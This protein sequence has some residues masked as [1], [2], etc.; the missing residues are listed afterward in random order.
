LITILYIITDLNIGGAE[1][2][3]FR[4]LSKLDKDK[5]NPVVISIA[6]KGK[7]GK[8]IEKEGIKVFSLNINSFI[9][10]FPGILKLFYR[11]R[12]INPRIIHTFLVHSALLSLIAKMKYSSTIIWNIFSSDLSY[13]SNNYLTVIVI[14]I[15]AL[16]SKFV[17]DKIILDSKSSYKAHK[18]AGYNDKIMKVIYN[19]IDTKIFY[20]NDKVRKTYR[21]KFFPN[22]NELVIGLIARYHPVKG[23]DVFIKAA[24]LLSQQINNVKFLLNGRGVN[25]ENIELMKLINNQNIKN[26]CHFSNEDLDILEFLSACDIL[27]SSSYYESFPMMICEAMSSRIPCVVTNV[28][29]CAKIVADTGI[30]VDKGDSIAIAKSLVKLINM[31]KESRLQLGKRA[32]LRIKSLFSEKL[33][34]KNYSNTYIKYI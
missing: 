34:I 17:P 9:S 31:N 18:K 25:E 16:L 15:C 8:K 12:I 6:S 20:F 21:N 7:I 24:G 32:R 11:I 30:I 14:K 22:N 13:K 2:L 19:G 1:N 27:V 3:L 23:H 29:D 4:L 26:I 5:Y 33:M 10:L 28:G